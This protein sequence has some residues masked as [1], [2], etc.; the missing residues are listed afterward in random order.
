MSD[1]VANALSFGLVTII[2]FISFGCAQYASVR[3]KTELSIYEE[4]YTVFI[5]IMKAQYLAMFGSFD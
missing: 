4:F 5:P 3:F 2:M 1:C